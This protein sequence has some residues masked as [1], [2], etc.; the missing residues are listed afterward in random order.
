MCDV[1][2]QMPCY[3][4]SIPIIKYVLSYLMMLIVLYCNFLMVCLLGIG[5][6]R[7]ATSSS[8][9]IYQ[10]LLYSNVLT[11]AWNILC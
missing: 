1:I 7:K 2:M 5:K 4:A 3:F 9:Y 11:S 10:S 6:K 8:M